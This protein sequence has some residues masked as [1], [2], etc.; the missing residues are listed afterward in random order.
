MAP[1]VKR[2]G[3]ETVEPAGALNELPVL[4]FSEA[5]QALGFQ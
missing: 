5:N 2:L 3:Q 1:P 4:V